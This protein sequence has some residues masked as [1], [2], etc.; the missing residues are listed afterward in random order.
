MSELNSYRLFPG[1]MYRRQA[2]EVDVII[3]SNRQVPV[4]GEF[5]RRVQ[6][7]EACSTR[8]RTS[9]SLLRSNLDHVWQFAEPLG[10]E[11]VAILPAAEPWLLRFHTSVTST[12]I[13]W[14]IRSDFTS[15]APTVMP[16]TKMASCT[17]PI[18]PFAAAV[19][20]QKPARRARRPWPSARS[21]TSSAQFSRRACARCR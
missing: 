16:S 3:W 2:D 6:C 21:V 20:H 19:M 18:T 13:S 12:S 4:S 5:S 15:H 1:L 10:A 9:G 17:A 14:R 11:H 8:C 7:R